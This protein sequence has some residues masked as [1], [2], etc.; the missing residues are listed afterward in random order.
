MRYIILAMLAL[1]CESIDDPADGSQDFG[2]EADAEPECVQRSP[3]DCGPGLPG[4]TMC[5]ESGG[6][7]GCICPVCQPGDWADLACPEGIVRR[8]CT[9]DG[10]LGEGCDR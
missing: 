7:A 10:R 1:G 3:C 5:Y 4:K 9:A 8:F 6:F 2:L